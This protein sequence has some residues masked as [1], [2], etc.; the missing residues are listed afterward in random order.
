[1]LF[2][3]NVTNKYLHT[4][5]IFNHFIIFFLKEHL[6]GDYFQTQACVFSNIYFAWIKKNGNAGLYYNNMGKNM[7]GF[8]WK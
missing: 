8:L 5:L 3:L 7:L 2:V 6:P 4:K 1:M